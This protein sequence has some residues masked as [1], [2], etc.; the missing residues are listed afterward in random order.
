MNLYH[1][2]HTCLKHYIACFF[3]I[4]RASISH[5]LE[6]KTELSESTANALK[7]L[8][9]LHSE[10]KNLDSLSLTSSFDNLIRKVSEKAEEEACLLLQKRIPNS[11][12]ISC[13]KSSR[14]LETNF[15]D[16][17]GKWN[18][19]EKAAMYFAKKNFYIEELESHE[20][21]CSNQLQANDIIKFAFGDD[22]KCNFKSSTTN[23]PYDSTTNSI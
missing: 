15:A 4:Q 10:N 18:Y 16:V 7:I 6:N 1:C 20:W 11:R 8:C 14:V 22:L 13:N 2:K 9:A 21:I 17:C 23:L 19:A 3:L 5:Q 12:A